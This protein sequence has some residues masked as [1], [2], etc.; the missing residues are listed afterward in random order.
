VQVVRELRDDQARQAIWIAT[1][2]RR[3]LLVDWATEDL[4]CLV[5]GRRDLLTMDT[6]SQVGRIE[7]H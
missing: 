3:E 1:L 5:S 6:K 2:S 4:Q 7:N